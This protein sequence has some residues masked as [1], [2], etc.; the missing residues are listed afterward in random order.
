M[1]HLDEIGQRVQAQA[2]A[3]FCSTNVPSGW[4]AMSSGS[5]AIVL[6]LLCAGADGFGIVPS[7]SLNHQEIT[8]RAILNRTVEVCRALA[9][10]EGADFSAPVSIPSV[11]TLRNVAVS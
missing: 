8:E 3:C 5:A 2:D 10:A 9:L 1:S 7:D 6:L 4:E 11:F